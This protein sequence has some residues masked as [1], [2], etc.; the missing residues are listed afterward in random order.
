M[1]KGTRIEATN[2]T[3]DVGTSTT[4]YN[5]ISIPTGK[6]FILTD[7]VVTGSA[8]A[9]NPHGLLS[10]TVFALYDYIGSGATAAS[11]VGTARLILDLPQVM[12]A[13][14]GGDLVQTYQR[15]CAVMH[16]TEGRG[17]EFSTGV[18]PGMG[19]AANTLLVGTG[20]VWLAGILR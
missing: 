17:P 11:N 5:M 12:L 19:G 6:T 3:R 7:I 2:T 18:T 8:L 10:H 14:A 4:V 15:G 16:F 9:D 13:S 20:C 1:I